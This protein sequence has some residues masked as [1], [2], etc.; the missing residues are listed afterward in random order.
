MKYITKSPGGGKSFF[1]GQRGFVCDNVLNFEVSMS[2]LVH[3]FPVTANCIPRLS[4]RQAKYCKLMTD[5]TRAS[6]RL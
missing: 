1:G 4:L 6:S 5:L 2:E 3:H